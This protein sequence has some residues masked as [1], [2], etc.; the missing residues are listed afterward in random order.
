M[1]TSETHAG[2]VGAASHIIKRPRLTKMLDET[3]ARIIL[4]C[5]PAGYGK[6]TLA[7]EWVATRSEPVHWYP[8][9]RL[10]LMWLRWRTVSL[11][12]SE[13]MNVIGAESARSLRENVLEVQ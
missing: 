3:E 10:W 6:T 9:D 7:R 8:A 5:A 1:G 2:A 4:L 13:L 11:P 12:C